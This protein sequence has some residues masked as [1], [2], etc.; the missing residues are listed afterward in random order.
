MG[1]AEP[2]MNQIFAGMEG[3]DE[4]VLESFKEMYSNSCTYPSYKYEDNS[5]RWVYHE[6][7]TNTEP[8][9]L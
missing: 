7:L 8:F 6:V 3:S 4:D 9:G 5:C 2:S 1:G